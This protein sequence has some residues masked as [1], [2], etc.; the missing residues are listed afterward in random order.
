M[1]LFKKRFICHLHSLFAIFSFSFIELLA[2][3]V[4]FNGARYSFT[5]NKFNKFFIL[6]HL[7]F[8]F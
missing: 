6:I 1:T 5:L 3:K 4:S 7:V 8:Y 2:E